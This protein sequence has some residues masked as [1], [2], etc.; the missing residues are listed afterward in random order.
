MV[1]EIENGKKQ[2]PLSNVEELVFI[3]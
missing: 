1:H 3:W 2:M